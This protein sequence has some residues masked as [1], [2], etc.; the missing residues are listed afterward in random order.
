MDAL[1][2][3]FRRDASSSPLAGA[4]L[5]GRFEHDARLRAARFLFAAFARRDESS[6]IELCSSGVRQTR[7]SAWDFSRELR[8]ESEQISTALADATRA[9]EQTLISAITTSHSYRP[10]T[11]C[12]P[13]TSQLGLY[14]R[15]PGQL[16]SHAASALLHPHIFLHIDRN[17]AQR[18]SVF[19]SLCVR[20]I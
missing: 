4:Y 3:Q 20:S 16:D 12:S 11:G 10:R 14:F 6:R 9:A 15:I 19:G 2:G 8:A 18:F 7:T 1:A 17:F 13:L 5:S